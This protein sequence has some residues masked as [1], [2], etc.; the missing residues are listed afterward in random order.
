MKKLISALFLIVAFSSCLSLFPQIALSQKSTT[1]DSLTDGRSNKS[2]SPPKSSD[3]VTRLVCPMYFISDR[4]FA[5][6]IILEI[7]EAN[8][9]VNGRPAQ[10]FEST[11]VFQGG[12]SKFTID[13]PLH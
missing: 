12:N 1:E 8:A 7:D 4:K 5:S 10:F 11:I 9:L 3:K 13:T 6:E 2:S